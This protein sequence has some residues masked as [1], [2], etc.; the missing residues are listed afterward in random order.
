VFSSCTC[1]R[2]TKHLNC[3]PNNAFNIKRNQPLELSRG[4]WTRLYL[5]RSIPGCS[6]LF[7]LFNAVIAKRANRFVLDTSRRAQRHSELCRMFPNESAVVTT[8]P[9]D[10]CVFGLH[11]NNY[12]NFIA[13]GLRRQTCDIVEDDEDEV[14]NAMR[15]FSWSSLDAGLPD[16]TFLESLDFIPTPQSKPH[17]S[18]KGRMFGSDL[19]FTPK[20]QRFRFH[21][22]TFGG[23]PSGWCTTALHRGWWNALASER[24]H[25]N[26]TS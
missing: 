21:S 9:A 10:L 19:G 24:V 5:E 3:F 2:K 23:E 7:K 12:Y 14:R 18:L 26:W 25:G 4:G 6:R 11:F 17:R 15:S 8:L 22:V 1:K 20:L 13:N 16:Q